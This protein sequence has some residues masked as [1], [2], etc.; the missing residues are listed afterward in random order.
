MTRDLHNSQIE[1]HQVKLDNTIGLTFEDVDKA[2]RILL[3][4]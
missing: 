4:R 2:E 1:Q 3:G